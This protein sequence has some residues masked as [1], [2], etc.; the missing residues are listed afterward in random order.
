MVDVFEPIIVKIT[1]ETGNTTTSSGGVGGKGLAGLTAGITGIAGIMMEVLSILKDAVSGVLKPVK[2]LIT[3]ILKLVAQLLRPIVDVFVLLL[4][5]ILMF[6]RPIIKVLNEVMRPFRVLAMGLMKEAGK[7][8]D[9]AKSMALQQ[10]AMTTIFAGIGNV[11]LALSGELL[12]FVSG[13]LIDLFGGI[14]GFFGVNTN[15]LKQDISDGID[16]GLLFI[17]YNSLN[18]IMK[19][20][21][22]IMS[23][24]E[25]ELRDA[26]LLFQRVVSSA[27]GDLKKKLSDD[28][29]SV[30]KKLKQAIELIDEGRLSFESTSNNMTSSI[31][32]GFK[33]IGDSLVSGINDMFR[34]AEAAAAR[35]AAETKTSFY[36]LPMI[37]GAANILS[38]NVLV[39]GSKA[40]SSQLKNNGVSYG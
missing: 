17:Q 11:L 20:V 38:N 15:K 30:A 26:N 28:D 10:T 2:T 24:S 25:K 3:G 14:L 12:K 5:P 22:E 19:T 36:D 9:K 35:K 31:T 8:D 33:K 27:G 21:T 40:L 39:Q 34:R 13:M 23:G 4:A 16:K 7:T 6:L 37:P 18:S 32:G 1:D 29:D